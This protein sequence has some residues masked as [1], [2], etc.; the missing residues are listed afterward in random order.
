MATYVSTIEGI[1]YREAP[2]L[3]YEPPTRSTG[4]ASNPT[5]AVGS[6]TKPVV[7]T[8]E[9]VAKI[10]QGKETRPAKKQGR[11]DRG[12]LPDEKTDPRAS[13]AP[14]TERRQVEE[15]KETDRRVRAHEQAHMSAGGGL[16]RGGA[17]Y[18]FKTASA[19]RWA[20]RSSW[21]RTQWMG[22]LRPPNA[23]RNEFGGPRWPRPTHRLRTD[24]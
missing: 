18:Q 17:T 22:I 4:A 3:I 6:G 13:K 23:R 15:L 11:E 5:G 14:E 7:D 16:V 2:P 9:L 12:A 8:V 20:A 10:P 24:R 1:A 21:T 19:M